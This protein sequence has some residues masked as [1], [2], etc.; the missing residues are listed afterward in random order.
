MAYTRLGLAPDKLHRSHGDGLPP[1]QLYRMAGWSRWFSPQMLRH[2]TLPTLAA[3]A[4]SASAVAAPSTNVNASEGAQASR[5]EANAAA[6]NWQLRSLGRTLRNLARRLP[7]ATSAW[8]S[9]VE[10]RHHYADLA[11]SAK[12]E[13]IERWMGLHRPDVVLDLGANTGEFSVLCARL[14][15]RVIALERDVE[16]ARAAHEALLREAPNSLVLVQDITQPSPAMGWRYVERRSLAQR[17]D[18]QAENGAALD[19]ALVD[20]EIV[21]MQIHGHAERAL[22]SRHSSDVIDVRVG[23]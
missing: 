15:A 1:E 3:S 13:A 20:E 16:S 18:G 17:L 7:K 10:T 19:R 23:Q 14:G 6:Q 2:C 4:A 8:Q 9:Y 11:V 12:R 21:S 22:R 5:A